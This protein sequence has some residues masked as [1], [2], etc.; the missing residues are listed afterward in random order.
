MLIQ[1]N[2]RISN[3][4]GYRPKKISFRLTPQIMFNSLTVEDA[5]EA[6]IQLA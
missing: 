3:E 6:K 4:F 2:M 5:D 1:F